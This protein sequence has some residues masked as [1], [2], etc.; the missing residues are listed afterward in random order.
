MKR[1]VL[2]VSLCLAG[3]ANAKDRVLTVLASSVV[4]TGTDITI[5]ADGSCDSIV[6]IAPI[7]DQRQ[8][9]LRALPADVCKSL[10]AALLANAKADQGLE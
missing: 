8:A 4:V 7:A 1:F 9:K 3:L 10:K 6:R 5:G 2:V